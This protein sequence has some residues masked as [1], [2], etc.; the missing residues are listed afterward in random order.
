MN[1]NE[2]NL[3]NILNIKLGNRFIKLFIKIIKKLKQIN[4]NKFNNIV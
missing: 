3:G 4:V 2:N 1:Y